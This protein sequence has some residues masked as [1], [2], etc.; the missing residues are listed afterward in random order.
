MGATWNIWPLFRRR[1]ST[2]SSAVLSEN[3]DP[4][5][6]PQAKDTSTTYRHDLAAVK[7]GIALT[8]QAALLLQGPKEKYTLKKDHEIPQVTA[9]QEM[10]IRVSVVGLNPIDWKAPDYNFGIPSFPFLCGRDLAGVVIQAPTA[11]SHLKVGDVVSS[12]STDYRDY[13]KAAF[14]EYAVTTDFNAWRIPTRSSPEHAAS[15]GVAFITSVFALG[16]CLGVTFSAMVPDIAAP[17]LFEQLSSLDPENIPEDVRGAVTDRI[18]ESDRPKAG[19]WIAIWGGTSSCSSATG[20][21]AVQLAKSA[22]L[23]VVC[24]ADIAKHGAR[25]VNLGADLLIDR[26]DT[27]RAVTIL[28]EVTGGQLRFGVDTVGKETATLLRAAMKVPAEGARQDS[29][30]VGL[31]G[32]PKDI[33]EGITHHSVPIKLFHLI[34]EIGSGI[35]LWLE[36]LVAHDVI[37]TPEVDVARGGLE[38]VNDA[39]DTMRRGSTSGRRVVVPLEVQQ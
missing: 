19:D 37:A 10:L 5:P 16:A 17:K 22:G 21:M 14:Q 13:R 8:Q 7:D 29:H 25:L 6:S 35:M 2:L 9:E 20:Y 15:I 1:K 3:K 4:A 39:L 26:L 31:T 33:I 23:R 34:P 32:L 27:D 12:V 30:L 24:V 36:E 38:G 18:A 28:R 11:P